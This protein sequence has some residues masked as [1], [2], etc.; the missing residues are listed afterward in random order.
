MVL[1][2]VERRIEAGDEKAET[3]LRAMVYQIAKE[4]GAMATVLRGRVDGLLLTGGMA[5]SQRLVA[6]LSQSVG[7]IAPVSVYAGEDELQALA[8]GALRVLR[9]EENAREFGMV[10]V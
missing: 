5:H 6:E 8:E 7:W 9:G 4:I 3:V 2:E 1:G 10:G